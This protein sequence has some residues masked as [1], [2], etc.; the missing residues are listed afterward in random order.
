MCDFHL[1]LNRRKIGE[2]LNSFFGRGN[3]KV[4]IVIWKYTQDSNGFRTF[5]FALYF[6]SFRLPLFATAIKFNSP[7]NHTQIYDDGA[8]FNEMDVHCFK[9]FNKCLQIEIL[10]H[11]ISTSA[12]ATQT[13]RQAYN[14]RNVCNVTL[15]LRREKRKR[16]ILCDT[17][18]VSSFVLN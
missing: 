5:L 12:N 13:E 2:I 17:H 7:V 10:N 1:N 16:S 4:V 14:I 6:V 15:M 9:L 11:I 8:H 3:I 18:Q